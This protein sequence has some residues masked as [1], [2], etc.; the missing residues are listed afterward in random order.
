MAR[1]KGTTDAGLRRR[2]QILAEA[3][4]MV[5]EFGFDELTMEAIADS[6][7]VA[8]STLYHYFPQKEDM[9]FA[10]HE[11]TMVE[12]TELLR[13]IIAAPLSSREKIRRVLSQ[14]LQLVAEHRGRVQ[15]L[16]DSRRGRGGAFREEMVRLERAY[17]EA[18]TELISNGMKSGEV[19]GANPTIVAEAL[20]GMTQH[21]RFWLRTDRPGGYEAVAEELWSIVC[22]GVAPEPV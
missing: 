12:Q 1:K 13:E 21:A 2:A 19:R 3:E 22:N 20:L 7:G 8:K 17:L 15:V 9:I 10:I 6:I 16:Q 14:Q 18:L 11:A 4:V 5:E